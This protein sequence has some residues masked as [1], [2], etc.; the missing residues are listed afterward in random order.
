[1]TYKCGGEVSPLQ[2]VW[3]KTYFVALPG[4]TLAIVSCSIV[5]DGSMA[6]DERVYGSGGVVF[7]RGKLV[8]STGYLSDFIFWK[9]VVKLRCMAIINVFELCEDD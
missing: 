9:S 7:I 4:D 6:F 2:E 3:T 1:V 8:T 5:L